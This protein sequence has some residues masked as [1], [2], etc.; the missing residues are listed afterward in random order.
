[1][2]F[3]KIKTDPTASFRLKDAA[4]AFDGCDPLDAVNDAEALLEAAK[5]K[6]DA[7]QSVHRAIQARRI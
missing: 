2:T 3:D 5:A 4:A 7:V 1:M 6:L